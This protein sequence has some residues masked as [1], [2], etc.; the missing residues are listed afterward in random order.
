MVD[1]KRILCPVDLS[2]F[3]RHA[4]DHALALA[5]WY[6]ARVTVL[7]VFSTPQPLAPAPGMAAEMAYL[8]PVQPGEIT[9]DVR[10]SCGPAVTAIGGL[11]DIEVIEGNAAKEIVRLAEQ[12]PADLVV[13]GTHGRGGFERLV[14][15]SV[16]E[17]VLRSTDVPVLTVPP[18]VTRTGSVVYKTILCAIEF[19]GASMRALEY[20]LSLAEET[21]AH[22]ILLHVVEGILEKP[23]VGELAHFSVPE[24]F[25]HLEEDAM[26]RLKAA[27]PAEARVWC[28]P[29]ERLAAGK[30]HREILRV[31][32]EASAELIVMG[33]HGKGVLNR[34]LLGSTTHRVIREAGCPVLTLRG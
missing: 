7:H 16:T 10:R 11:V 15:G 3:S 18:P 23:H 4:L 6:E 31:A 29:D 21:D 22:L 34:R 28:K 30:A 8:P 24:Y 2:E 12:L 5:K 26:D 13:T 19:S 20:A 9:E 27:V 17:K 1:I 33:V 25:R 14:L 32:E